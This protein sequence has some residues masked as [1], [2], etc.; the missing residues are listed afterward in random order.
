MEIIME[1]YTKE[2][3]IEGYPACVTRIYQVASPDPKR[4]GLYKMTEYHEYNDRKNRAYSWAYG[5]KN[6]AIIK[7]TFGIK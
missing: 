4:E 5:K 1:T 7:E 6:Q 2:C 3:S